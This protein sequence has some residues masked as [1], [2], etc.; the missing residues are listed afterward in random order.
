MIILSILFICFNVNCLRADIIG[1]ESMEVMLFF[2][3]VIRIVT[4]ML[5]QFF[6]KKT[7]ITVTLT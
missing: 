1:Q 2:N 4:F 5:S 7:T 6:N 3:I